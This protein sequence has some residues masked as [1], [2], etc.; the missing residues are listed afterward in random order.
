MLV[1]CQAVRLSESGPI[2]NSLRPPWLPGLL[3]GRWGV[4]RQ[5]S[6]GQG[7]PHRGLWEKEGAF[8]EVRAGSGQE[9]G[10]WR[11]TGAP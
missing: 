10:G 1:S 8:L 9:E 4:W 6:L 7:S 3:R 5:R 11:L 2:G